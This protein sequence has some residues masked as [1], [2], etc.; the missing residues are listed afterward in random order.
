MTDQ[1]NSSNG[2]LRKV[3]CHASGDRCHACD[4]Y[5]GRAESC[6]FKSPTP[7]GNASELAKDNKTKLIKLAAR[8]VMLR[9]IDAEE[10]DDK[11]ADIAYEIRRIANALPGNNGEE[12]C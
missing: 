2:E 8:V 7:S 11:L 1:P 10:A 9:G 6:K 4:H 5:Y 12:K 3:V